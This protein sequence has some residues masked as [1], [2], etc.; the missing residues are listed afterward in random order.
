MSDVKK[1]RRRRWPWI[2]VVLLLAGA[3]V[4]IA[5]RSGGAHKELDASLLVP[6][7]RGDLSI[8]VIETGKVQP[9]ERVE[10]KSKVAGQVEQVFVEEGARV[11]KGQPLLRLDATD[12]RR[13]VARAQAEVARAEADIAQ[14]A[15]SLDFA[16]LNLERRRKGLENR[17]VAQ[18]DVDLAENELRSKEVAVKTS[19]SALAGYKVALG[20]AE[21]R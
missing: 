8:E 9:R 5:R 18:V 20:A 1:K 2:V 19:Q 16:K 15:N 4:G 10:I 12:F 13:D 7:K 11:K 21:D 6:V 17:G 3:G 14:V